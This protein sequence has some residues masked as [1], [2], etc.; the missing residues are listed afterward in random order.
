VEFNSTNL[1]KVA[2]SVEN[3]GLKAAESARVFVLKTEE[4]RM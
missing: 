2:A 4:E 1:V 3:N